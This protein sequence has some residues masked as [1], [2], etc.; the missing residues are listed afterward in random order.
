MV[1]EEFGKSFVEGGAVATKSTKKRKI[2]Y[3]KD[4]KPV[5][6]PVLKQATKAAIP[7]LAGITTGL[8]APEF[9]PLA[10]AA[11]SSVAE[12]G[13]T[14]LG[15]ETGGWGV[16]DVENLRHIPASHGLNFVDP[17]SPAFHPGPGLKG[18]DVV[19]KI[20]GGSF[21]P[22]GGYGIHPAMNPT[23]DHSDL[24]NMRM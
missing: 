1:P 18:N 15:K 5:L 10:A 22:A 19:Q 8:V 23:R 11:A 16:G 9:A 21:K 17:N 24:R 6:G 7:V 3:E 4:V 20:S 12:K 2:T 13:A 14:W